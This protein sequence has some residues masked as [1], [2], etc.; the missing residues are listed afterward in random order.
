MHDHHQC[1]TMLGHFQSQAGIALTG[2]TM[3]HIAWKGMTCTLEMHLQQWLSG[4]HTI[5]C[6]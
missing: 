4:A 2:T 6:L 1:H 5:S 3:L